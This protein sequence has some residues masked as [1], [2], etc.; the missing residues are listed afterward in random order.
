MQGDSSLLR[1]GCSTH[2]T[3]PIT[4]TTEAHPPGKLE[5]CFSSFPRPPESHADTWWQLPPR[6]LQ[7]SHQGTKP[8]L[9]ASWCPNG[10]ETAQALHPALLTLPPPTHAFSSHLNTHFHAGSATWTIWSAVRNNTALSSSAAGYWTAFLGCSSIATHCASGSLLLSLCRENSYRSQLLT[11][12][13]LIKFIKH[14][15]V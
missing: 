15:R 12:T 6:Q 13:W 4:T 11:V 10:A 9:T 7:L 14:R 8:A 2:P 1:K 5:T 3:K